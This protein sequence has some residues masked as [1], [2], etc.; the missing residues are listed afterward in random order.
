ML[1]R[2][3]AARA[4]RVYGEVVCCAGSCATC[5]TS[6]W[7]T[8]SSGSRTFASRLTCCGAPV[9]SHSDVR[10]GLSSSHR[11]S[12]MLQGN[13]QYVRMTS[14]TLRLGRASI[15]G[16]GLGCRSTGCAANA[17]ACWQR[18]YRIQSGDEQSCQD[19][20]PPIDHDALLARDE[21]LLSLIADAEAR[22]GRKSEGFCLRVRAACC[23]PAVGI[24][25]TSR[26]NCTPVL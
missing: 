12:R 16:G 22:V 8:C 11:P 18:C 6:V 14:Q 25:T 3:V 23:M 4:H 17:P 2:L 26:Q 1:S 10:R 7:L 13:D 21:V 9:S 15:I 24:M 19:E 5:V 20:V